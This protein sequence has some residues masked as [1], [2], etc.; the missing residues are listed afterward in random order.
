MVIG[1]FWCFV[2]T[3]V[4]VMMGTGWLAMCLDFMVD[5]V[6]NTCVMETSCENKP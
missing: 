6:P 3:C 5:E 2:A 4:S 1:W